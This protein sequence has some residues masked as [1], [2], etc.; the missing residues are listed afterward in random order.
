VQKS[1]QGG[2]VKKAAIQISNISLIRKQRKQLELV[3][4][5]KEKSKIFKKSNQVL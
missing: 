1:P 2:I 3:L 4:E 5:L